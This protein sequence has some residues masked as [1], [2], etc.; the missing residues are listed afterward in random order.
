MKNAPV[1]SATLMLVLYEAFGKGWIMRELSVYSTVAA[2]GRASSVLLESEVDLLG[3]RF[4][5]LCGLEA[6]G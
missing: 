2:K 1:N 3:L 4:M 5:T 6:S